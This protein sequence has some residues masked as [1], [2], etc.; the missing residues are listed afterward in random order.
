MGKRSKA[1]GCFERCSCR[2][3]LERN[4]LLRAEKENLEEQLQEL[5]VAHAKLQ[6][7]LGPH[8]KLEEEHAAEA[9]A[10]VLGR[11]RRCAHV[12]RAKETKGMQGAEA[13]SYIRQARLTMPNCCACDACQQQKQLAEQQVVARRACWPVLCPASP[14]ARLAMAAPCRDA[15]ARPAEPY[16]RPLAQLG[17][18]D[19]SDDDSVF[20]EM[21]E[22]ISP[23]VDAEVDVAMHA[24]VP[25]ATQPSV[26]AEQLIVAGT[27][28]SVE[29]PR[30][31]EEKLIAAATSA[32]PP[33]P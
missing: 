18:D 14:A 20:S 24:I 23:E 33:S 3:L 19:D 12:R 31:A 5:Q 29:N 10:V 25:E 6:E 11:V 4:R 30:S 17:S 9:A 8:A 16:L 27:S 22:L 1:S 15:S 13:E 32:P 7:Q 2:S 21:G 26:S 28:A